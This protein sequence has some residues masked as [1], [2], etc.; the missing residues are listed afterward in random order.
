[1]SDQFWLTKVQL[2]RLA[3]YFPKSRGVPRKDDLQDF[4]SAAPQGREHVREAQGLETYLNPVRPLRP[5]FL[6]RNLHCR[7]SHLLAR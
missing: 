3:P 1:M 7:N 2:R 5:H 4:V 6:Q